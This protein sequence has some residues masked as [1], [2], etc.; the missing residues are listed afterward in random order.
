MTLALATVGYLQDDVR[1]NLPPSPPSG[2][3][4]V[5]DLAPVAPAGEATIDPPVPPPGGP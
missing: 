3:G 1:I 2:G 4:A 5:L